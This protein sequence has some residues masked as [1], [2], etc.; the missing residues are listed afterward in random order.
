MGFQMSHSSTR[1][2]RVAVVSKDAPFADGLREWV[3]LHD[4]DLD[5]VL[6]VRS[7]GDLLQDAAFPTDLVV[8]DAASSTRNSIESRVRTLRASGT[9]VLVMLS[10]GATDEPQRAL[11]AGAFCA[12]EK[13]VP[14]GLVDEMARGAV[15]LPL[16]PDRTAD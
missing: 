7:W 2:A 11:S 5:V 8:L 16:G 10:P 13:T 4:G 9:A 14:F 12:L 1:R 3:G 15:G 6:S